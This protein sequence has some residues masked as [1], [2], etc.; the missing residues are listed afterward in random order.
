MSSFPPG[1]AASLE[2]ALFSLFVFLSLFPDI[3]SSEGGDR[4]SLGAGQGEL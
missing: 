1:T 2:S 3:L 4:V